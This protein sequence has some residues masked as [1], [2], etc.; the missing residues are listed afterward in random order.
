MLQ[1]ID[2]KFFQD[3]NKSNQTIISQ[4]ALSFIFR[5]SVFILYKN[6]FYEKLKNSLFS[7]VRFT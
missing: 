3:N 2:N 4:C 1:Q 5:F 6:I 7:W